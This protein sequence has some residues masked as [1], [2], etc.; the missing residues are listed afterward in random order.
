MRR[1]FGP[2]ISPYINNTATVPHRHWPKAVKGISDT[3]VAI[4][5]LMAKATSTSTVDV[6]RFTDAANQKDNF[7]REK[8]ALPFQK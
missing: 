3:C 2:C 6:S 5:R 8:G 7:R 4:L 1:P